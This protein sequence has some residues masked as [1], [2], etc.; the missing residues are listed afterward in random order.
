MKNL[1]ESFTFTQNYQQALG[2][3]LLES[4]SD[5]EHLKF[6]LDRS[7]TA[8]CVEV[9][10]EMSGT[11][12]PSLQSLES[13][14]KFLNETVVRP[15]PESITG[16]VKDS[17]LYFVDDGWSTIGVAD[18]V[19][20]NG[21]SAI[22]HNLNYTFEDTDVKK[23]THV[24]R[25]RSEF[26]KEYLKEVSDHGGEN[27]KGW[28]GALNLSLRRGAFPIV[29]IEIPSSE[30]PEKIGKHSVLCIGL[31]DEN[32]TYFD[33]DELNIDR[34]GKCR[35]EEQISKVEGKELIYT[36]PVNRF[37]DRMTGEVLHIF[38]PNNNQE[39]KRT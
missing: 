4:S 24:G 25:I 35:D 18:L 10:A 19:R 38:T 14:V 37:L 39:Q 11:S 6:V 15:G 31:D 3:L 34:Y 2:K 12:I 16:Q 27:R 36:Q 5:P 33:P 20:L 28:L 32:M 9:I 17:Q 30:F 21:F 26:E 23:M 29:S 22:S 1:Q 13:Y 7:C 8:H